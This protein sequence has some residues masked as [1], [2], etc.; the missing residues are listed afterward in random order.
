MSLV[1]RHPFNWN[2]H[3]SGYSLHPHICYKLQSFCIDTHCGYCQTGVEDFYF[4]IFEFDTNCCCIFTVC[5]NSI[6]VCISPSDWTTCI[7]HVFSGDETAVANLV[8]PLAKHPDVYSLPIFGPAISFAGQLVHWTGNESG[9]EHQV[10]VDARVSFESYAGCR[11]TSILEIDNVGTTAIY[12]N[13]KV[14]CHTY[15]LGP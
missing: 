7:I 10:A 6:S 9:F 11:S 5:A 12:F 4:K 8:D 2:V 13:W 3:D 1:I 14:S 15:S